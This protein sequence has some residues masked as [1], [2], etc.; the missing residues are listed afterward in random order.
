MAR[1]L[2]TVFCPE[3]GYTGQVVVMTPHGSVNA[4]KV[5]AEDVPQMNNDP[6][7][8][9][10]FLKR[11]YSQLRTRFNAEDVHNLHTFLPAEGMY[12]SI[13]VYS[14]HVKDFA[15]PAL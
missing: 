10:H 14:V 2:V 12:A 15:S 8:V 5:E 11:N 4:H 9:A 13:R 6:E 7:Y 3:Y 1:Y